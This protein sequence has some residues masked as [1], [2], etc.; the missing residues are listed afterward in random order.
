MIGSK[1]GSEHF[2]RKRKRKFA[3]F[4]LFLKK[5]FDDHLAKLTKANLYQV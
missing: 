4:Y 3:P 5:L 2:F 1:I